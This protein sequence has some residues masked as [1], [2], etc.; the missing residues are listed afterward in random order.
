MKSRT[1]ALALLA[2]LATLTTLAGCNPFRRHSAQN[3]VCK[4]PEAYAQAKE[5]KGL[6]IPAGLESPD[7]RSALRIPDL[8]T[9][10]PPPRKQADGCLDQPPSYTLPKPKQ[11]ES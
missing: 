4:E 1:F 7:T 11:P 8:T 2:M 6:T 3:E 5:A 10:E 9:A